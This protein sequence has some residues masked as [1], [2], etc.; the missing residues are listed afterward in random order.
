MEVSFRRERERVMDQGTNRK[1]VINIIL[2]PKHGKGM[3]NEKLGK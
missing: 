2:L 3:R 1:K